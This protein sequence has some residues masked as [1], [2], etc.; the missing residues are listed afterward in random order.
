MRIFRSSDKNFISDLSALQR[1]SA[2]SPQ[3]EQTVREIIAAV[4]AKGDTALAEYTEKFGG[5]KLKAG[6][7]RVTEA[8]IQAAGK[9]V[10]AATKK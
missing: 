3:V 1:K 7:L 2:P 8:E 4:R 6:N 10:D 5:P 9:R